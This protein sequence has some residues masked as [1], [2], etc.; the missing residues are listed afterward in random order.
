MWGNATIIDYWKKQRDLYKYQ[1]DQALNLLNKGY[2]GIEISNMVELP[3]EF[4]FD[5][6]CYAIWPIVLRKRASEKA[7]ITDPKTASATNCGHTTSSP[8]P[9]YRIACAT[10]SRN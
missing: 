9:R 8:A 4:P 6:D 2:T 1:H 3:P 5:Q 10:D 7:N